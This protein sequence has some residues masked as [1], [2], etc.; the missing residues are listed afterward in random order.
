MRDRQ[1]EITRYI[2]GDGPLTKTIR[3]DADGAM[4]ADASGCLMA[5]GEARRLRLRGLEEL[6]VAIAAMPAREAI[7]LGALRPGLPDEVAIVT[8]AKLAE[9]N[10]NAVIARTADAINYRHGRP[11]L[12][13]LDHDTKGMP[14]EVAA[15]L[16]EVGGFWLAV[17][18]AVPGL[19]H[20]ARLS[21][22]STS[23]GLY[24]TDTGERLPGGNGVHVYI[25]ATNG[26]D[27]ERFL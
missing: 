11:A 19:A 9:V 18:S 1:L 27:V 24:R 17:A 2:K 13:L 6:A 16:D 10:G 23:A 12:A 7:G 25:E 4:V 8:K 26:G 5:Q 22:A 15:R 21:R 3:L 14:P 20:A